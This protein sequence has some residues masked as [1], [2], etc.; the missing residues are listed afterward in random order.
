MTRRISADQLGRLFGRRPFPLLWSTL[1]H[2]PSRLPTLNWRSSCNCITRGNGRG[3]SYIHL[4]WTRLPHSF[5]GP[6]P[7]PVQTPLGQLPS[8]QVGPE[9]PQDAPPDA[10]CGGVQTVAERACPLIKAAC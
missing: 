3:L 7:A 5:R 1:T 2:H 9:A 6:P 4:G 8:A 10:L